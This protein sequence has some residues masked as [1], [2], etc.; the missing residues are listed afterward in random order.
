M[1]ELPSATAILRAFTAVPAIVPRPA[2]E[3]EVVELFDRFRERLLRYL[4]NFQLPVADAEEVIQEVFLALFLHLRSGKSRENLRGW[5]FR[6]AHNLALKRR[7]RERSASFEELPVEDRTSDPSPN[8]EDQMLAAQRQERLRAVY[9]ALPERDR[10]CL[11]LRAEGL[12]YREIA[13]VLEISL[14][15]VALS[16]GRSLARMARSA[17]R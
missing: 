15:A 16:L 7:Q 10:R 13:G 11:W 14:G 17:E 6:V 3:A 12:N 2:V 4:L 1:S 5:L 9:R 8:P